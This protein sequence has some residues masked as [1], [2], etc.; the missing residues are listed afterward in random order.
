M[1]NIGHEKNRIS[2]GKVQTCFI[3]GIRSCLCTC[4]FAVTGLQ[5][6]I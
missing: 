1:I 3:K 6:Y 2:V 5:V 4:K